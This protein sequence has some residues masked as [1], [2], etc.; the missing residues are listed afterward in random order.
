MRLFAAVLLPWLLLAPA[1]RADDPEEPAPRTATRPPDYSEWE[2]M[3][4]V[5]ETLGKP[6]KRRSDGNGGTVLTYKFK[7]N[8]G[9]ELVTGELWIVDGTLSSTPSTGDRG[10]AYPIPSGGLGPQ[11]RGK[12][13]ARFYFNPDGYV[14]DLQLD[15]VKWKG[16]GDAAGRH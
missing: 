1:P 3:D 8:S 9:L 7:V 16:R 2:T 10:W 15:P 13:K 11:A 14:Y 6:A 5:L 12:L 4:K